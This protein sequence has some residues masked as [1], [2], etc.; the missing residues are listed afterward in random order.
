MRSESVPVLRSDL[1]LAAI[2][3]VTGLFSGGVAALRTVPVVGATVGALIAASLYLA[4][5][6]VVPGIYPEVA[7]V[8]AFVATAAVAV[9]FVV[10]LSASTAVVGAAALTGGGVGVTVYRLVF[11]VVRPVPEYRLRKDE[12]PEEAIEPE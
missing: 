8:A 3:L 10:V 1:F 9:G 4:E 5:H 12:E 7:S 11:G 2:M 6:D